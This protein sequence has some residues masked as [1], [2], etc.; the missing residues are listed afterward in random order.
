MR[1]NESNETLSKVQALLEQLITN[2]KSFYKACL[3]PTKIIFNFW[4]N[5]WVNINH[6]RAHTNLMKL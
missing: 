4:K 5:A 6:G 1:T 3:G 2:R